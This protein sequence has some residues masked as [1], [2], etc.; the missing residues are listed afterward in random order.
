VDDNADGAES[1]AMVL[2]LAGHE[3]VVAHDG[4]SGLRAAASQQPDVVVLDIGLPGMDGYEAA[5][6]LRRLPGLESAR[7]IALTG[8][9]QDRD[10][11]AAHAAGFDEHH[12][13]PLDPVA[14]RDNLAR[15]FPPP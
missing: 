9:G 12:V 1:L 15:L 4:P 7:L 3:V 6:R 10:R 8:Y 14:F 2:R 11:Q 13:K 5:R